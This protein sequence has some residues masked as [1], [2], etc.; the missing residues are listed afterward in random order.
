MNSTESKVYKMN[1]QFSIRKTR[2]DEID[3]ATEIYDIGRAYMRKNGNSNQ[4]SNGYP[5]SETVKKDIESGVSYVVV[6]ENDFPVCVFAFIPGDD[7]TYKTIYN[8]KWLNDKEYCTIHRIAVAQQKHG[9][10]SLVFDWASDRAE[11]VR[12]DTH[13]DNIP[14]Q[15]ALLKN[16]FVYCG[17]IHLLNGDERLAYQKTAIK[18]E[19]K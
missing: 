3:R 6:N 2:R 15:N 14:M 1:R 11:N 7:P 12:V 5:D 13:R 4:W 10:A 9:L 18:G 8:G 19:K 16:G 17:V